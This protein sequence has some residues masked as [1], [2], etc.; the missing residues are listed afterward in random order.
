MWKE[1]FNEVPQFA[2]EVA[3]DVKLILNGGMLK[4]L[5]SIIA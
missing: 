1:N 5:K 2:D 3:N 4:A